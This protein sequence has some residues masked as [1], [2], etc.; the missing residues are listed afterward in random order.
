MISLILLI[1]GAIL[2]IVGVLDLLAVIAVGAAWWV[3][4]LVGVILLLIGWYLRS[5][6][7]PTAV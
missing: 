1:A 6:R 5:G 7:R 4:L 2:V 3:L